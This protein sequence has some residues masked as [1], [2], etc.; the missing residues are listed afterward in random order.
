M[1]ELIS[2]VMGPCVTHI[3]R[4]LG[5]GKGGETLCKK[6]KSLLDVALTEGFGNCQPKL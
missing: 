5:T 2:E 3:H 6:K 1:S 4:V